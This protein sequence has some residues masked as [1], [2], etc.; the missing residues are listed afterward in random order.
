MEQM[1]QRI[2]F[3]PAFAAA[4]LLV[5]IVASICWSLHHPFGAHWDEAQYLNEAQLDA[6][7]LRHAML[8]RLAGRILIKSWG[9]P[10]AYRVLALPLLG[11]FGFH[12]VTVRLV[13]L[14]CF[15][16]SSLFVYLSARRVGSSVAGGFAVLIFCLSPLV[17]AASMWFST[18]GPLYLATAAMLYYVF[19][20]WI[21][22]SEYWSNWVGLGLALG[23][24]LLAKA[25]FIVIAVPILVLWLVAGYRRDFGIPSLASQ[26]RAG[27]LA[28]LVA[29]PWWVLNIK[30]AISTTQQARGFVAN[31]LGPPS[32]PLG[33]GGWARWGRAF[34]DTD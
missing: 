2:S 22:K 14:A 12:T 9:R 4:T 30:P 25:S 29:A 34:S 1:K 11:L 19:K 31:S 26:W 15:A 18:E 16:L 3:W 5:I 17:M 33:C 28:L 6:Q 20:C 13:S 32:Q 21:D 23:T 7:R 24:G 10:P 27:L 8:L